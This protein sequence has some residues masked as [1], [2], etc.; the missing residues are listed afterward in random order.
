MITKLIQ[1][2]LLF[3]TR[4]SYPGGVNTSVG[5]GCRQP[6]STSQPPGRALLSLV[7]AADDPVQSQLLM[8]NGILSC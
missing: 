3:F 6:S 2:Q 1:V 5:A 4:L 8:A 7:T